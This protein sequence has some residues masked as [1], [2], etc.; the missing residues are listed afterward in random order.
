ML[1]VGDKEAEQNS[2][3]IRLRDGTMHN[4]I[5]W[6]KAREIILNNIKQRKLTPEVSH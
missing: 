5:P 4:F 3:S 1:I 2:V 6:E